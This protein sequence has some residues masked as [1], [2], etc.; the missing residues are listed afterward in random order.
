MVDV[1]SLQK[2]CIKIYDGGPIAISKR[3]MDG[4]QYAG[5]ISKCPGEDRKG[6]RTLG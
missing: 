4:S 5:A 3:L 6:M 1:H 2:R